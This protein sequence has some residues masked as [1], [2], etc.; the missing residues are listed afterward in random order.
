MWSHPGAQ[1]L[2]MG[3]E[4]AQRHEWQHDASLDWHL[5]AE[6]SHTGVLDCLREINRL[7]AALP[8]SAFDHSPDGFAWLEANDADHSLRAPPAGHR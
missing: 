8:T 2:F 5:L 1:L 3:A 7:E 4:F 6:P